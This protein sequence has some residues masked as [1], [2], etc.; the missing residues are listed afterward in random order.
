LP[1]AGVVGFIGC[2]LYQPTTERR[3]L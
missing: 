3:G 1:Q 2:T